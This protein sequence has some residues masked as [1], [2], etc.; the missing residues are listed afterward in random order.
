MSKAI[1]V[2]SIL[3]S[4]VVLLALSGAAA[5]AEESAAPDQDYQA[6]RLLPESKQVFQMSPPSRRSVGGTV[7][8]FQAVVLKDGTIGAVEMLNDDRPYPGVEKAAVDTLRRWRYEPARVGGQPVDAGVT[9]SLQ[10]RGAGALAT[11]RPADAWRVKPGGSRPILGDIVFPGDG[12][13]KPAAAGDWDIHKALLP[14]CQT[15]AGARC[16]YNKADF[17]APGHLVE[18]PIATDSGGLR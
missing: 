2:L 12:V 17:Q 18:M 13:P 9:I 15:K 1:R 11:T 7:L 8:L 6:P 5:L 10:F 14:T 16:M 4:L 3:F